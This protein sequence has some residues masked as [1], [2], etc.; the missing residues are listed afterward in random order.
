MFVVNAVAGDD[1]ISAKV[2]K[3][4]D[5]WLLRSAGSRAAETTVC[6]L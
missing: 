4:L 2:A 3:V 1:A 6:R 5:V